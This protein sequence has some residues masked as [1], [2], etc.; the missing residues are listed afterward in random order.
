MK[1]LQQLMNN[2]PQDVIDRSK[3][4]SATVLKVTKTMKKDMQ[5][6][7]FLVRCRAITE[8]IFYDVIIELY[9]T[10]VHMNVFKRPDYDNPSWVKCSCPFFLFNCEYALAS[11]GSSEIDY[12][13]GKPPHITNPKKVPFLCKHLYRASP[14]AVNKMKAIALPKGN[15]KFI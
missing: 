12:S 2:T 14:E 11:V 9:P 1:T 15:L 7:Q 3:K 5:A 6:L 8:K 10:E 13:N 4:T